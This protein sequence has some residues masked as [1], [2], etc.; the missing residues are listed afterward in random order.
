MIIISLCIILRYLS[1]YQLNATRQGSSIYCSLMM[2]GE[3]NAYSSIWHAHPHYQPK[4]ESGSASLS[5]HVPD[6]PD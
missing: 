3:H 4:N 1:M 6:V 5:W 2:D